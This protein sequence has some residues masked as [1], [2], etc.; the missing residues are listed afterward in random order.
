MIINLSLF[1]I[2][3]ARRAAWR[4]AKPI[5]FRDVVLLPAIACRNNFIWDWILAFFKKKLINY[6]SL[7][8]DF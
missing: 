6:Q 4:R 5:V 1:A 8:I 2:A 7:V 3:V